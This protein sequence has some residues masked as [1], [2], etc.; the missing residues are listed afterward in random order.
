M[1][2]KKISNLNEDFDVK[3]FLLIARKN[4]FWLF[5]FL[6]LGITDRLFVFALYPSCIS[7]AG[8]ITDRF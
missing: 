8:N 6:T 4:L 1:P 5:F 2:K 3:L 7:I